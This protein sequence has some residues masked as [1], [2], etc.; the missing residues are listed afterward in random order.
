M[1]VFRDTLSMV[2]SFCSRSGG[3][4]L[5]LAL[6]PAVPSLFA[7]FLTRK[8]LPSFTFVLVRGACGKQLRESVRMHSKQ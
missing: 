8:L 7:S 5:R 6:F 1:I 2:S 3:E 4:V